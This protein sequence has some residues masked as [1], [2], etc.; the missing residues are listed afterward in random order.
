[1]FMWEN[2]NTYNMCHAL[3]YINSFL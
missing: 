3:H 2:S 1:M